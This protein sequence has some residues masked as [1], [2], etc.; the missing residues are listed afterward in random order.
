MSKVT[1]NPAAQYEINRRLAARL[2][3]AAF[4]LKNTT[5]EKTGTAYPPAS[6]PGQ[7]IRARTYAGH[8]DLTV[9][10]TTPD[11]VVRNGMTVFVGYSNLT[12]YMPFLERKRGRLGLFYLF[13]QMA[14]TNQLMR[15]HG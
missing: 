4:Q 8:D 3:D 15:R 6:K 11:E 10:P 12:W 7:F 13:R 9:I 14:S 1:V 5:Q 2:L